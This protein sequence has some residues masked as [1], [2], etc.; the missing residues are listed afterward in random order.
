MIRVM[1][2]MYFSKKDSLAQHTSFKCAERLESRLSLGTVYLCSH[3]PKETVFASEVCPS[4][5]GLASVTAP[6]VRG[7][8]PRRLGLETG[9]V[10]ALHRR[11]SHF[12]GSFQCGQQIP[13]LS[14]F[15]YE[16]HL[17]NNCLQL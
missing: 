16:C 17:N 5:A 6:S 12:K 10:K 15:H 8:S 4:I 11:L 3:W 14:D 7:F 9:Y 1:N 13:Y 2:A